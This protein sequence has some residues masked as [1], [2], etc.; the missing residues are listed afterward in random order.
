MEIAS[1]EKFMKMHQHFDN[2]TVIQ[3]TGEVSAHEKDFESQVCEKLRSD[4]QNGV[5]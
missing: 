5:R 4:F 3:S 1:F 2:S